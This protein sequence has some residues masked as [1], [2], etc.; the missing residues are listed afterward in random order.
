MNSEDP[1]LSSKELEEKLADPAFQWLALA[2]VRRTLRWRVL[3]VSVEEEDVSQLVMMKLLGYLRK[4]RERKIKN[5]RALIAVMA[6]NIIID[7]SRRDKGSSRSLYVPLDDA[8]AYALT[9]EPE[10]ARNIEA[11]L[12]LKDFRAQLNEEERITLD[13]IIEGYTSA[14]MAARMEISAVAARQRISRLKRRLE[15]HLFGLRSTGRA[16]R[17]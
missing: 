4:D 8:P 2:V 16:D 15:E 5:W 12:V 3:P 14:G 7:L 1:E 17:S 10:Q 13:C 11:G 9:C 6:H